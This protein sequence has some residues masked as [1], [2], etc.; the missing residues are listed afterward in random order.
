MVHCVSASA[1]RSSAHS[2]RS[3]SSSSGC[4]SFANDDDDDALLEEGDR[5]PLLLIRDAADG[6]GGRRFALDPVVSTMRPTTSDISQG[7][8]IGPTSVQ[9]A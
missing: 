8:R 6:E 7:K 5:P 9:H 4:S 2:A 3:L 1:D